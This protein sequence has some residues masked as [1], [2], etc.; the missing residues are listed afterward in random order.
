MGE[1][2]LLLFQIG[3]DVAHHVHD[4]KYLCTGRTRQQ[5]VS[6]THWH[7]CRRALYQTMAAVLITTSSTVKVI[8]L[9]RRIYNDFPKLT[10]LRVP[11]VTILTHSPCSIGQY[12]YRFLYND[13][14]FNDRL[15]LGFY[16]TLQTVSQQVTSA[17]IVYPAH[18]YFSA[19]SA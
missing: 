14:Y 3:V 1:I 5:V 11:K 12:M 16:S 4:A 7:N 10:G 18:T 6:H 2:K 17:W 15:S 9:T 19:I 8:I 13:F